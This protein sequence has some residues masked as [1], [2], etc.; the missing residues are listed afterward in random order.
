MHHCLWRSLVDHNFLTCTNMCTEM[1][2]IGLDLNMEITLSYPFI[3]TATVGQKFF[4][5]KK[6]TKMGGE[7]EGGRGA[8]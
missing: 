4:N 1:K 7:R 5:L 6:T 3:S 8:F 2:S